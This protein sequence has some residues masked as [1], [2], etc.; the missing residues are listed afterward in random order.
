MCIFFGILDLEK[1]N[2]GFAVYINLGQV[3][4]SVLVIFYL[5]LFKT[6]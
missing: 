1:W 6:I 3:L 5:C 2:F 4:L